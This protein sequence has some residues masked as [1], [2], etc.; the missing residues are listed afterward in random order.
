MQML[1]ADKQKEFERENLSSESA[2]ET[3]H[4]VQ[5]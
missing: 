2:P 3:S 4:Y 1:A 5:G